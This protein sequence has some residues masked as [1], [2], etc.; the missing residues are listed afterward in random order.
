M[1]NAFIQAAARANAANEK[2]Y[3]QGMGI[4]DQIIKRYEPG[5]AFGKGAL[6]E[7]ER[8]KTRAM[9][10]GMQSLVSSG[11][12]NTTVAATM[13]KKYEEEVGS[14]FRLQLEDMR[15]DRLTQAQMGQTDFI[16]ARQDVGP[17]PSMAYQAGSSQ[18]YAQTSEPVVYG[19]SFRTEATGAS[20]SWGID[21]RR[22]VAAPAP[23]PAPS[24]ARSNYVGRAGSSSYTP[25]QNSGYSG[26]FYGAAY[27][28]GA[29]SSSQPNTG[30]TRTNMQ[31]RRY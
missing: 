15:M 11:L 10:S 16:S 27:R 25:T 19:D 22:Q 13:D 20:A 3:Q 5:G 29:S 7:Y 6:A 18:G 12:A 4:W 9:S 17:D 28:P 26:V 1:A 24:G 14:P 8:G 23:S 2:R 31:M 21:S 30:N